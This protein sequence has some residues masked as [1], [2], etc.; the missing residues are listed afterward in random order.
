MADVEVLRGGPGNGDFDAVKGSS[1]LL[2][3]RVVADQIL[4]AEFAVDAAFAAT[5]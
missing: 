4:R 5:V 2:V 1:R 3:V